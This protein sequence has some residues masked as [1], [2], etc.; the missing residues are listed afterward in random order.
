MT[1]ASYVQIKHKSVEKDEKD[2]R[3]LKISFIGG[4]YSAYH[5]VHTI[6]TIFVQTN[7]LPPNLKMQFTISHSK[8]DT[9]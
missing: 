9:H 4:K 3:A 2:E 5:V 8:C 6:V 1:K 7:I